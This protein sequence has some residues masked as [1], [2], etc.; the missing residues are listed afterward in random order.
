MQRP[1]HASA[2]S[3]RF[4]NTYSLLFPF[5]SRHTRLHSFSKSTWSSP[6][7][8]SLVREG[9]CLVL[10]EKA[11]ERHCCLSETISTSTYGVAPSACCTLPKSANSFGVCGVYFAFVLLT[12]FSSSDFP[13]S[14]ALS[15]IFCK[16]DHRNEFKSPPCP[17]KVRNTMPCSSTQPLQFCNVFQ[18]CFVLSHVSAVFS[19]CTI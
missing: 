19:R 3:I 12:G 6:C 13:P 18:N 10:F 14:S 5:H 4:P 8:K 17:P 16:T 1:R 7:F 2:S 9:A 11:V 15:L